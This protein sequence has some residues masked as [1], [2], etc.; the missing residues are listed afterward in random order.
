MGR[1][2]RGLRGGSEVRQVDFVLPVRLHQDT[3]DH[4]DVD[5][6][7][8][9]RPDRFEHRCQA[10]VPASPQYAIGR[11]DDQSRRPGGEGA[12][13]QADPIEFAMNELAHRV[14][15]KPPGDDRVGHPALEILVHRQVQIA[16]QHRL[17][18][19][20]QGCDSWESL[21]VTAAV[22]EGCPSPTDGHRRS[23]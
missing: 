19:Q 17:A 1:R 9:R 18:D 7:P 16:Q 23:P 22:D 5:R 11:A 8:G 12:M 10:Q 21:P 2:G 3:I 14:I 20:D 13:R 15:V 4:V 6:G